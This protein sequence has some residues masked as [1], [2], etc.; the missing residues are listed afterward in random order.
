[1]WSHASRKYDKL[2]S[3]EALVIREGWY[4]AD[5]YEPLFFERFANNNY[6]AAALHEDGI[7]R[8][9]QDNGEQDDDNDDDNINTNEDPDDPPGIALEPESAR[10]EIEGVPPP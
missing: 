3:V 4:L 7:A 5:K 9:V 6:F 10:G 8:V 2:S 1:M